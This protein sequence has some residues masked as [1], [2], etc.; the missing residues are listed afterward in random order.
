VITADTSPGRI[1][2]LPRTDRVIYDVGSRSLLPNEARRLGM[3]RPLVIAS[4]TL[5]SSTPFVDEL[6]RSV[7]AAGRVD[8]I[9]AHV[10]R[11]TV[12]AVARRYRELDADGLISV[13]GGSPIDC[14]KGVA[15]C[16]AEAIDS[17]EHLAAYRIRY[18]H[19]GPPT[20]P[21]VNGTPPQHISIPTTLSGAE[22]TSIVGISDTA[23]GAKDLYS[24]DDL[25]PKVVLLDPELAA[26]TPRQLWLTSG[27]RAIDHIV[28]GVYST[29]H[30]PL[31]DAVLV[32]A[33][34]VLAR[35][36]PASA[37]DPE[38]LSLRTNCQ[39][40]AWMAIMHLKNVSTG[41]SH[42]LGH[43]LGAMLGVPHGVTSCILLPHAMDF[44]RPVTADRQALL[45]PALGV[46]I[47]GMTD[48]GAAVAAADA[49][50]ALL[51][52]MDVPSRLSDVGV[53]RRHFDALVSEALGDMVVA[54]NPRQV[55]ATDARRL[56]DAAL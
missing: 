4:R 18:L 13:G 28:E 41:I 33:L 51:A 5:L 22:F 14:A 31:T 56:L 46:D 6:A 52:Q 7:G 39:V 45:A 44:N 54:G 49:I 16:V 3:T 53:E 15:L 38:D 32:G 1:F 17:E 8:G 10:P 20:I 30:T 19:P 2:D 48:D 43:Q 12:L 34:K 25:C 37:D 21:T 35:D 55:T 24:A 40:A 29:R 36:L 27:V 50:R 26:H 42:G 47:T 9:A 11:A 23:R